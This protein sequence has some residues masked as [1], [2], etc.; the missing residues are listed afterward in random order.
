MY[1]FNNNS[2]LLLTLGRLPWF[3]TAT[4]VFWP[5]SISYI[6]YNHSSI[7][8]ICSLFFSCFSNW[9]ILVLTLLALHSVFDYVLNLPRSLWSLTQ[10]SKALPTLFSS[11][12]YIKSLVYSLANSLCPLTLMHVL[13][14][15]RRY[16]IL[17]SRICTQCSWMKVDC[18]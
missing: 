18:I 3:L 12:K 17:E 4:S 5:I 8:C 11:Y 15:T 16:L 6:I 7:V 9:L 13:K 14:Q 2:L 1:G 10:L